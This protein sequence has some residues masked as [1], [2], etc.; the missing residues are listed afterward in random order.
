MSMHAIRLLGVLGFAAAAVIP[1]AALAEPLEFTLDNKSSHNI[2]YIYVAASNSEEWGED[3]LG[4][5]FLFPAGTTGK[6]TIANAD[7]ECSYDLQFILDTKQ[8]VEE[9]GVDLC[10]GVTYTL[11]DK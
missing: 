4:E 1:T 2:L 5:G 3:L 7:G 11:S 6:V 8:K 9:S 10:N